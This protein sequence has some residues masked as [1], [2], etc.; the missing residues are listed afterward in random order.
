MWYFIELPATAVSPHQQPKMDIPSF[1]K[2]NILPHSGKGEYG[3]EQEKV[4]FGRSSFKIIIVFSR[5]PTFYPKNSN[6]KTVTD[7]RFTGKTI[8]GINMLSRLDF[9][10]GVVFYLGNFK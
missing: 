1:G 5:H 3:L 4:I 8:T 10:E 7:V 9:G 6:D 2:C